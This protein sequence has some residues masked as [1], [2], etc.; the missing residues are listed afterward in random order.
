[1]SQRAGARMPAISAEYRS[2]DYFIDIG[3]VGFGS[4]APLHYNQSTESWFASA[5]YRVNSKL[6]VGYYHSNFHVDNPA[7]P[8][9][10]NSNHIYDEVGTARYDFNRNWDLKV[11]GH[12]MNGYGDAYNAQGFYTR[13]NPNGIKPTTDM[14]V[15][16][17]S[18]N[19]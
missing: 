5:A 4:G 15:M 8:T 19:F 10:P 11:E 2:E 7:V 3:F 14:L 6:Q 16:R 12:F 18:F 1:M 13:W 9:D 17:T